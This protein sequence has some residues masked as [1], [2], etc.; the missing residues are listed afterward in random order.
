MFLM[1]KGLWQITNSLVKSEDTSKNEMLNEK[2]MATIT[3][4]LSDSQ[5]VNVM[6]A[7]TAFEM[8]STIAKG[9]LRV[10]LDQHMSLIL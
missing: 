4:G 3:L 5:I 10:N 9:S 8:W 2:A 7:E 6:K 1:S